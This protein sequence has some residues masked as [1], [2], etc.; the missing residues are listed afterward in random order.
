M[1]NVFWIYEK[2]CY[3]I[4]LEKYEVGEKVEGLEGVEVKITKVLEKVIR[5]TSDVPYKQFSK[6]KVT[7][8]SKTIAITRC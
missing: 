8:G 7:G 1:S 3:W 4:C 2:E 6:L 5:T